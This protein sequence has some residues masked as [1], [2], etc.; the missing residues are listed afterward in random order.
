MSEPH[1]F[2][3]KF[4][5]DEFKTIVNMV[6]EKTGITIQ[7]HKKNMIYGRIVKRIRTLTLNSFA[8]YIKFLKSPNSGTEIID[9]TNAITTN[10]TK[11]FREM[12]HFD[13][14]VKKSLPEK[15]TKNSSNRRLRIWSAGCSAGMEPY[16]IAMSLLRAMPNAH[17][18]DA[19]ILATDI[20][21]NMLQTGSEGIYKE[22][23]AKGIPQEYMDKYV[24]LFADGNSG[25][26]NIKM[27][28]KLQRL[29]SFK[30]LNL[31][32]RFPMKGPF[33]I[34]FCRNVVIYFNKETQKVLFDK[35]AEVM[36]IGSYL[37]VGHSESLHNVTD[38]FEIVDK[39][40]YVRVK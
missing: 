34:V 6:F 40:T 35:F 1:N 5:D 30:Q 31:M 26:K 27:S 32:D 13:H 17:S 23:D 10:L 8:E 18:W 29:I 33:D 38:R 19:K 11:F 36:D 14:L 12:H 3:F 24:E 9:F 4:S 22:E 20:D 16:S 2:E 21:T 39:T 28:L 25:R 15:I 7:P 37:Y